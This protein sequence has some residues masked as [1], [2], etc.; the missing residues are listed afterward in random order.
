M[1]V[2]LPW[3]RQRLEGVL[4]GLPVVAALLAEI[5]QHLP[6]ST[7][8]DTRLLLRLEASPW[9]KVAL[10]TLLTEAHRVAT[11]IRGG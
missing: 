5:L 6:F 11:A 9:D 7:V 1:K 3:R 4:G 2:M 10:E 8:E